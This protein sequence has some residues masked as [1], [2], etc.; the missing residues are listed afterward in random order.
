M[1]FYEILFP[2]QKVHNILFLESIE[3]CFTEILISIREQYCLLCK[4]KYC[5]CNR[6]IINCYR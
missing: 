6:N 4:N 1:Y 2:V 5:V 3:I